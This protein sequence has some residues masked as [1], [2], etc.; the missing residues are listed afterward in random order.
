MKS[1]AIAG[2]VLIALGAFE[3]L[4]T[5]VAIQHARQSGVGVVA[6]GSPAAL[7]LAVGVLMLVVAAVLAARRR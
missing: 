4:R 2:V 5:I 7:L 6:G 1:L 3:L